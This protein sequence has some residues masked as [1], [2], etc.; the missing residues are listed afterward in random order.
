MDTKIDWNAVFDGETKDEAI[1]NFHKAYR[2]HW[3]YRV[4]KADKIKF[5]RY[6]GKWKISYM[7]KSSENKEAN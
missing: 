7:K 1:R 4:L 3:G 5:G 6:A 2:K